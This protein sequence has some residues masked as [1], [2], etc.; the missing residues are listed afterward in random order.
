MGSECADF[1]GDESDYT[2]STEFSCPRSSS[3]SSGR[4]ES[5]PG[6]MEMGLNNFW[7]DIGRSE[8]LDYCS[9]DSYRFALAMCEH[10]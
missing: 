9:Q 2:L 6:V 5:V 3:G 10:T 1:G 4:V 8:S 7:S